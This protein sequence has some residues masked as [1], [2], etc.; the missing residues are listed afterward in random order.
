MARRWTPQRMMRLRTIRIASSMVTIV[1]LLLG[2]F[3]CARKTVALEVNGETTTVT[4][5]ATT[6]PGFQIGRAHV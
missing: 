5:F 2:F 6:I 1:A 3:V 4:T